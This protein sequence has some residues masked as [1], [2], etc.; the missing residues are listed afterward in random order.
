MQAELSEVGH[1]GP[2]GRDPTCECVT[3]YIAFVGDATGEVKNLERS[4]KPS[5]QRT[6][7]GLDLGRKW[8]Y[9]S[10]RLVSSLPSRLQLR[11]RSTLRCGR[12]ANHE[13]EIPP[14]NVLCGSD[15]WS[16]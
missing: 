1:S 16:E 11:N 8:R 13:A 7:A 9:R 3:I 4:R 10:L 12:E 2:F 14:M 15:I 5:R 6:C